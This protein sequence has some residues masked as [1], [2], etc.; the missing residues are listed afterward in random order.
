[1][2][3]E[4][5]PTPPRLLR[6]STEMLPE[7]ERFSA[8][9]EEFARR[10]LTMDVIDHSAGRPRIDI[11]FLPL[12]SAAAGS[13]VATPAEFVRDTG[14]LKDG[15]DDFQLDIVTVGPIE[16]THAG[17]ERSYERGWG[18]FSDH[19]RTMRGFGARQGGVRNVT[20]KAVA[21]KALVTSPEDAAG[22]PV[23]PG[24]AL[25]LLDGY[26]RSLTA[27]DSPP[28]PELAETIGVHLLDLM[29]AA[30][31][32]TSDAKEM[33]AKRGV[34]VARLRAIL[35]EIARHFSNLDFNL[36]SVVRELGL[37][38]RYI[39]LVL[40][41]T[42]RSFT[43]HLVERR[44]NRSY[45]M[46]TDHRYRHLGVTDIAFASGFGDISHFNRVFRRRFGA[47][48]SD[49]RAAARHEREES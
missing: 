10:V 20:V 26:L 48:P 33:V 9:R 24:P 32:P 38:R 17:S 12:G 34:K 16:Y 18:Y 27:L 49:V 5:P 45:V 21:L 25:R 3:I 31:G 11:A 42:G 28:S 36:D 2:E 14:H 43:E 19:A 1:M 23:Y 30:L 7:R 35:L 47:T 37:S 39:Q 41:E 15:S 4:V 8:F 29:A 22:R 40:E 44:L 6:F 13:L 46:L